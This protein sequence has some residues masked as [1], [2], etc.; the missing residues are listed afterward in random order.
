MKLLA[1]GWQHQGEPDEA[2]QRRL[3]WRTHYDYVYYRCV[4]NGLQYI[5][6]FMTHTHVSL[7]VLIWFVIPLAFLILTWRTK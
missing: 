4:D 1:N 3:L 5:F 6:T 2:I 7:V